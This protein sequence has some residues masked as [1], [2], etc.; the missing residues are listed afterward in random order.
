MV[1][2]GVFVVEKIGDGLRIE[3]EAMVFGG[4]DG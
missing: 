4:R 3:R 1:N 2:G